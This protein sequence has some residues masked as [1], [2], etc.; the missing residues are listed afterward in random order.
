M[1]EESLL[2][3]YYFCGGASGKRGGGVVVVV[4]VWGEDREREMKPQG[5]GATTDEF[6]SGRK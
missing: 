6:N 2:F 3:V 1:G 4:C 5:G